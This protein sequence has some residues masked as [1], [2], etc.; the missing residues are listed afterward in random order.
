[1]RRFIFLS[2]LVPF[3][4]FSQKIENTK[5]E[6][7]GDKIIIT[8]DLT[9]G[10]AGDRYSVSLFASHNNF[11]SKLTKVNGDIGPNVTEGKGKR[12]E[13]ESKAE[14]G[15][16][17]GPLTFEI[18]AIVIA[19]LTLKSEVT[20]TKRGKTLPLRWRG[21]DQNQNVKIELLKGGQ[22]Q[23][24]VGTLSNKGFYEWN[25]PSKQPAGKDYTLRLVNG[26]ETAS[27]QPFA[28]KSK[29]PMWVK[30]GLPVAVIGTILLLP[31]SSSGSDTSARLTGP[32]DILN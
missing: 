23:G 12:I 32:P 14:V 16:Y 25:V 28:I 30:I 22:V 1:M 7:A 3:L 17:K 31:K 10:E 5:A 18:E 21:G 26:R 15:N 24:V 8:Y 19:P 2:M 11:S 6:V 20:S 27:S 29:I 4:S 13:W 9:Q